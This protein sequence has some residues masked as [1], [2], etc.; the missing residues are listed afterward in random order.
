[1]VDRIVPE[2]TDADRA[3]FRP[4]SACRR[5]AGDDRA[6][7]AMGG[8][9]SLSGRPA[10]FRGRR[11]RTRRR[12]DAV[13]ADEAAAAQRQPFGARLSRLS[14]R[15]RDHRRHHDRRSLSRASPAGDGRGRADADDARGHRS[16][17]LSRLAAQA[18]RQSGAASPHLADRDG[19]LAETAAAPARRDAG[20]P[21]AGPA[22]RDARARGGRLDALR[23]RHRRAGPRHR[24]ARSARRRMFGIGER[25]GPVA[26][27]LAPAL[28]EVARFSARL[29]PIPACVPLSPRHS[30]GS[31]RWGHGRRCRCFSRSDAEIMSWSTASSQPKRISANLSARHCE[32]RLRR[33]NP[34][35]HYAA[36]WIASLRSQ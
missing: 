4:R 14:R 23:H 32:E 7:H 31:M 27:R 2:T 21:A 36:L 12:R 17:R 35:I 28:L 9:G 25:T 26:E 6:V 5:L 29:A 1:M 30:R 20:P 10:G 16:R 33:S 3:R 8:R 34:S 22:D 15:L 13:R 18:L 19:R 11:R 24:R